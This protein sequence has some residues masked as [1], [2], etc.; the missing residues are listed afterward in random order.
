M[1]NKIIVV[2]GVALAL[3]STFAA[4]GAFA[5]HRGGHKARKLIAHTGSAHHHG[6]PSSP[7]TSAHFGL[8]GPYSGLKYVK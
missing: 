6:A 8:S 3:G 7:G 1:L 4:T 5:A 2:V